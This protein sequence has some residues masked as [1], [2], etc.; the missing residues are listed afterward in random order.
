MFKKNLH[1]IIGVMII[2]LNLAW[3]E[4]WIRRFYF[5]HYTNI[6][7]YFMYPDWVLILNT[8]I[9]LIGVYIGIRL[10]KGQLSVSKALTIDIAMLVTG[11]II[12]ECVTM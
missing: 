9:G 11:L 7:W 8:I 12:S 10:T 6:L 5:Y 1:R 4:H 3:T 2:I